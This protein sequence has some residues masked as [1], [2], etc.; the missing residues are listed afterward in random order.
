MEQV[1]KPVDNATGND[2]STSSLRPDTVGVSEGD[3]EV[4]IGLYANVEHAHSEIVAALERI[5]EGT[6]GLCESCGKRI[7]QV[8]LKAIP[9]ARRCTACS[10]NQ[11]IVAP[12]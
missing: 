2:I 1:R 9:Y 11:A 4:A 5:A 6:F 12:G 10:R 7:L 3:E 8:R